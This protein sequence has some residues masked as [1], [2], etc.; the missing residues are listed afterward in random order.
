MSHADWQGVCDG[1]RMASG[2]FWPIPITLSA[3]AAR[4][5][6]IR[7]GEDIA[8]VDPDGGEL[9]ATM[10]VTEK[11]AID[12]AHE[13]ACVF[14]TTDPA[15]PGVK[16]VHGARRGQPRRHG[17]RAVDGRVRRKVRQRSS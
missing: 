16:L 8:L 3:D 11:Y 9:L 6:S 5:A 2:L 14:R 15:H 4:A 17:P 10:L 13:C 7:T 12:K 1:M